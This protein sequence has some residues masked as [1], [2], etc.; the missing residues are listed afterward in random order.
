MLDPRN[1]IYHLFVWMPSFSRGL[2]F[3][4]S[5][6]VSSVSHPRT[7]G[8]DLITS[9]PFFADSVWIFTLCVESLSASLVCFQ[10]VLHVAVAQCVHGEGELK[11]VLLCHL[12]LFLFWGDGHWRRQC[13][14]ASILVGFHKHTCWLLGC[15]LQAGQSATA[16]LQGPRGEQSLATETSVI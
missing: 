11:S 7:A 6:S 14:G 12:D 4:I 9:P 5:L 2:E 13:L 10:W 15:T 8:T 16:Q 3:R 1:G